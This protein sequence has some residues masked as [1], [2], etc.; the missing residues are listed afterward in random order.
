MA[1]EEKDKT[2]ILVVSAVAAQKSQK[3]WSGAAKRPNVFAMH[4]A[5][6]RGS[7]G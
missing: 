7:M 5:P 2:P 1:M 6:S 3:G 4:F